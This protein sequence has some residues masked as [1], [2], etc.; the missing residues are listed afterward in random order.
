MPGHCILKAMTKHR[1]VTLDGLRGVAT[2]S[3]FVFHLFRTPALRHYNILPS[4]Y[5]A[6]DFFF[7]LSGFVVSKAYEPSLLAG[8]T[9][10]RFVKFRLIR[11]YPMIVLGMVIGFTLHLYHALFDTPYHGPTPADLY[12]QLASGLF[13]VPAQPSAANPFTTIYPLDNPAWSL[14]Y[15]LVS[16]LLWALCLPFLS[17]NRLTLAVLCLAGLMLY[18]AT[19]HNGL[20][21]GVLTFQYQGGLI[22]AVFSFTFGTL[23]ARLHGSG[24]FAWSSGFSGFW[25]AL[26]LMLSFFPGGFAHEWTYDIFCVFL[27]Y[28][29]I[30]LV[31]AGARLPSLASSVAL[32]LGELS[33]AIYATHFPLFIENSAP[34]LQNLRGATLV[35]AI[36]L[37]V[38]LVMTTSWIINTYYEKPVRRFLTKRLAPPGQ[39]LKAAE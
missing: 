35:L 32:L 15:E 31:G 12:Q 4:T 28:P 22:R 26:V 6:V 19:T 33:Y 34:I 1:F 2:L 39:R 13:L 7:L 20:D 10:F 16:N 5:L 25:P 8:V 30:L 37:A 18:T 29:I 23:L 38:A 3:I 21:L 27:L 17:K 9:F 14:F 11:L 24:A 36:I